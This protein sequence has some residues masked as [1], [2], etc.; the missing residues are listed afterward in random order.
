[1]MKFSKLGL[2]FSGVD[3]VVSG[4]ILMYVFTCKEMFCGLWAILPTMPWNFVAEKVLSPSSFLNGGV[5]LV[6]FILINA[7]ILYFGGSLIGRSVEKA[8]AKRVG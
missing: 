7:T 5:G 4:M 1:M 3:V 8:K 2:I 6:V